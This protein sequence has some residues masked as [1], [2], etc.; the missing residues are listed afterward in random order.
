ML[1]ESERAMITSTDPNYSPQ[2][3]ALASV[4]E[5]LHCLFLRFTGIQGGSR[6]SVFALNDHE[7]SGGIYAVFFVSHLK[8]DLAAHTFVL[9]GHVLPI[10][11]DIP[12]HFLQALAHLGSAQIVAVGEEMRAWKRLL[13]VLTERCRQNWVHRADCDYIK[14]GRVPLSFA[15][16]ESPICCCGQGKDVEDMLRVKDW[17]KFAP[18]CTRVAISPLYAVS[19]MESIVEMLKSVS[20]DVYRRENPSQHEPMDPAKPRKRVEE[21]HTTQPSKGCQK[22][23]STPRAALQVCGRCKNVRYCSSVCQKEDWKSHKS[24]CHQA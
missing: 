23:G 7:G 2:F 3:K 9:D 13:P 4:K 16:G 20:S 24:H 19:Y 18:R 22:C 8:L 5:T 17:A 15:M 11:L 10:T 14:K 6:A 1:S 21:R 12:R